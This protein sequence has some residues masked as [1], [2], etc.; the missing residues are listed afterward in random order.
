MWCQQL[1]TCWGTMAGRTGVEIT[2]RVP[3]QT[4]DQQSG[5][6]L[7]PAC[8]A[9]LLLPALWPC[10]VG[11]NAAHGSMGGAPVPRHACST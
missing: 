4:H 9:C 11:Y 10:H 1:G 2:P 5:V 6:S 7:S 8:S 3:C